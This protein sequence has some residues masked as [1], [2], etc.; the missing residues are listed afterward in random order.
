MAVDMT[1]WAARR[2]TRWSHRDDTSRLRDVLR[3]VAS[4][5]LN[6]DIAP[7]LELEQGQR[8][9]CCGHRASVRQAAH[10]LLDRERLSLDLNTEQGWLSIA[11]TPRETQICWEL[12]KGGGKPVRMA[13][14]AIAIGLV[15]PEIAGDVEHHVIRV[16]VTRIRNKLRRHGIDWERV[17]PMSRPHGAGYAWAALWPENDRPHARRS[18]S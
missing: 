4:R 1:T 7:A 10:T 3:R 11:L 2:G 17:L 15:E 8:C 5:L 9:P 16:N 13:T 6:L 12:L 14:V 18:A